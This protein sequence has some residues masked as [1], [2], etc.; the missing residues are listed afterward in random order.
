MG[1]RCL[2]LMEQEVKRLVFLLHKDTIFISR[3]ADS[4][5]SPLEILRLSGTRSLVCRTSVVRL[6]SFVF[7]RRPLYTQRRCPTSG[8]S[9][10][11]YISLFGLDESRQGFSSQLPFVLDATLLNTCP[12]ASA[13]STINPGHMMPHISWTYARTH[14]GHT[15]SLTVPF[16]YTTYIFIKTIPKKGN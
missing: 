11:H 7:R 12:R 10:N 1:F 13:S 3:P 6:A 2:R 15:P 5:A 9:A 16:F 8:L 4:V 14:P